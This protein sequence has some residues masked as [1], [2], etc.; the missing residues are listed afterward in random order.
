MTSDQFLAGFG[1]TPAERETRKIQREWEAY[2]ASDEGADEI[3]ALIE[4]GE[5]DGPM[6]DA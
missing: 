3:F 4:Q 6:G 2:M 5:W 1:E